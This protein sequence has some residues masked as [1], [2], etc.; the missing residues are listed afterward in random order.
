MDG[1]GAPWQYFVPLHVGMGSRSHTEQSQYQYRYG[2]IPIN[3]EKS[4][5]LV[6]FFLLTKK[7]MYQLLGCFLSGDSQI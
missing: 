6:S 2:I 7:E 3:K 4:E 1:L 5:D